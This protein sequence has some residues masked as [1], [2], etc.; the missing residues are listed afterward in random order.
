MEMTKIPKI[1]SILLLTLMLI[2]A[3]CSSQI[4]DSDEE[5][6]RGSPVGQEETSSEERIEEENDDVEV[7]RRESEEIDETQEQVNDALTTLSATGS[8]SRPG[9]SNTIEVEIT[10]DNNNI[11][12]SAQIK[13]VGELN[14]ISQEWVELY[15]EG[16]EQEVVGKSLDEAVSP[17]VVNRSS[18]TA[19]GFNEALEAMREQRN[20]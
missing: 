3:G 9:G 5:P 6:S 1:V 19:P 18:L 17:A 12:Q 8:Y 13:N 7:A 4:P 11:I 14:S 2:F 10:V 20:Q 16:I 15:N